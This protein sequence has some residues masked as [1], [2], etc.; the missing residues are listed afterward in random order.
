VAGGYKNLAGG[1]YSFA[2]GQQA[3][4]LHQGSFVWAD[5][6]N[7]IFPSTANDQFSVRAQGGVR[8]VTGGAGFAVDGQPALTGTTLGAGQL[9]GN[10][11]NAV[12]LTNGSNVFG[13]NGGGLT[14]VNASSLQAGNYPNAVAL[15]NGSNLFAG[16]GGGLTNVNASSLQGLDSTGFWKTSGNAGTTPGVNFLGTSDT[17]PLELHVNGHRALRL[18]PNDDL[19]R[20]V[21]DAPNIIAGSPH[22]FAGNGVVGATISG[23]GGSIIPLFDWNYMT[24]SVTGDFG[25]VGGGGA[26]TASGH[27]SAVGGGSTNTANAFARR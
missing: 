17:Q 8:F 7:A 18:E 6:Q 5:S 14:N 21:L 1:D 15:T 11:P 23:G 12:T 25:T 2:A 22:N 19:A 26:N 9:S 13:G 20:K 10:Y 27:Y 24:N 16:N 4:A 3:Q